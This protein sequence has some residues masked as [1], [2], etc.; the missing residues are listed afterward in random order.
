MSDA[1]LIQYVGF[2]AKPLV[3][4]YTFRVR[5]VAED[6]SEFTLTIPNEAFCSHRLKY[7]DAPDVCSLK[8]HRELEASANHPLKNHFRITNEE[9]EEYR[10]AHTTK[11]HRNPY[12]PAP[13]AAQNA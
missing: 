12:T 6:P 5:H 2:E 4:E 13:K 7:Q 9:L 10:S 1:V 11:S 3:R 8:L